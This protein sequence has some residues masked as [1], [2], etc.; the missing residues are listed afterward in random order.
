[1]EKVEDAHL[2]LFVDLSLCVFVC[3]GMF[4]CVPVQVKVRGQL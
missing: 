2:L 4:A 3:E 1:M